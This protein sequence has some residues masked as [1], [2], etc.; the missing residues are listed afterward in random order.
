MP[1]EKY[2][3]FIHTYMYTLI[4]HAQPPKSQEL[5]RIASS[6]DPCLVRFL[7]QLEGT[8]FQT[9]LCLGFLCFGKPLPLPVSLQRP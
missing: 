9:Y 4:L 5:E 8:H 3:E 1:Y 7:V 2:S 6:G